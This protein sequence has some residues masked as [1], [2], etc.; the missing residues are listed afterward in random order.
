M[1]RRY[2][3]D[4]ESVLPAEFIPF[5]P[6]LNANE[7]A[8]DK[9]PFCDVFRACILDYVTAPCAGG[10]DCVDVRF[11][12]CVSTLVGLTPMHRTHVCNGYGFS[13]PFNDRQT[14]TRGYRKVR[15]RCVVHGVST[16]HVHVKRNSSV[17]DR[18][19][20][21]MPPMCLWCCL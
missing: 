17:H 12:F 4:Y 21:S 16:L 5:P 9:K 15:T 14:C 7:D 19:G 10:S 6:H 8:S 3:I 11:R 18:F 13:T 2:P 20:L 1:V